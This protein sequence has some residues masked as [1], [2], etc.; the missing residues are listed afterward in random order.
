MIIFKL[1]KITMDNFTIHSDQRYG[2]GH[3]G[4]VYRAVHKITGKVY[5]VK[6]MDA[7]EQNLK[8]ARTEGSIIRNQVIPGVVVIHGALIKET[9]P[10][11]L[12]VVMDPVPG[13]HFRTA[14]RAMIDSDLNNLELRLTKL[15]LTIAHSVKNLHDLGIAHRDLKSDNILVDDQDQP[16][17]IDFGVAYKDPD[18]RRRS[19]MFCG[20]PNYISPSMLRRRGTDWSIGQMKTYDVYALGVLM[21]LGIED[22]FPFAQSTPIDRFYANVL[23]NQRVTPS[24][25]IQ[26]LTKLSPII[27]LVL[28]LTIV[29]IEELIDKLKEWNLKN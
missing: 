12:M 13:Q 6:V 11:R 16:T 18:N 3:F 25:R 23:N 15:Y 27:E 9:N 22:N 2:Q 14:C 28:G 8:I 5:A 19:T 7:S 20:T 17:I 4:I 24:P 1:K 10:Q 26:S 29:T 21:Y